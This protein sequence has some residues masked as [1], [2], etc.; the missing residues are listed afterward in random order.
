MNH[1]LAATVYAQA[2]RREHSR[3]REELRIAT[4]NVRLWLLSVGWE[5][6]RKDWWTP[7]RTFTV[8]RDDWYR[9]QGGQYAALVR[10]DGATCIIGALGLKLGIPESDMINVLAPKRHDPR[11]PIDLHA[12]A[13]DV[14]ENDADETIDDATREARHVELFATIG[15]QPVFLG[16]S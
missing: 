8:S 11:W 15:W 16:V 2:V 3:P 12:I 13:A 7:V 1:R 14:I 6:A 9:G 4:D 5:P 10:D